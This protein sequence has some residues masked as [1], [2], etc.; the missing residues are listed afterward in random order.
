MKKSHP[1]RWSCRV[2][3]GWRS[4]FGE[5]ANG[6]GFGSTH[7]ASCPECQRFFAACDDLELTLRNDAARNIAAPAAALEQRILR[8]VRQ[9]AAEPRPRRGNGPILLFAGV[10]AA[11]AI[12][13]G[14][15]ENV[16]PGSMRDT[17]TNRAGAVASGATQAPSADI[18]S[19]NAI[20]ATDPLQHEVDS[21]YADA[22]SA[23]RFLALNFLPA[24]AESSTR[25]TPARPASG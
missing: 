13:F 10:A 5:N 19:L 16:G 25:Q 22:Q 12:V 23:I 20:L 6:A 3:R 14:R 8:A 9:T 17:G 18:S 21:V 11:F 4:V 1:A 24:T 2:V 15:L 7:I